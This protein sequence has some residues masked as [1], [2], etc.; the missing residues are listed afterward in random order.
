MSKELTGTATWQSTVT[1]PVDG[2]PRN[3]ASVEAGFQD[4]MDRSEYLK[5]LVEGPT[6]GGITRIKTVAN[7]TALKALTGMNDGDAVLVNDGTYTGVYGVYVYDSGAAPGDSAPFLYDSDTSGC[8]VHLDRYLHQNGY[9]LPN[10]IY[11]EAYVGHGDGNDPATAY[12]TFTTTS[13]TDLTGTPAMSVTLSNL[14]QNDILKIQAK[15]SGYM[16]ATVSGAVMQTYIQATTAQVVGS[17]A[18][19][20]GTDLHDGVSGGRYVMPSNQATVTVKLRA[21]NL[22]ANQLTITNNGLHLMVTVVRP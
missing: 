16:S 18:A 14:L 5:D 21:K 1:C 9:F 2:D 10:R 22:G 13:W 7:I 12:Q 4:N 15:A 20:D 19:F 17:G 11:Q 8:W 3:A 6:G